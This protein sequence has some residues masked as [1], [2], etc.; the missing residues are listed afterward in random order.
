MNGLDLILKT[1][2]DEDH[3]NIVIFFDKF[4]SKK[5]KKKDFFLNTSKIQLTNTNFYYYNENKSSEPI[6]FYNNINGTI[7]DFKL[8]GS[9]IYASVSKTS[10]IDNYGIKVKELKTDFTYS[11]TKMLFDNTVLTTKNSEINTDMVFNYSREDLSDFNNKVEVIADIKKADIS[12]TDLYHFYNELGRTDK[13]HFTSQFKGTLNDF[14]L[15]NLKLKSD[16][17][18]II[19]GD[20]HFINAINREN[21]FVL[22]TNLTNLTSNYKQLKEL[23]PNILGKTLPSSF[24]MFGDF[25]LKGKSHITTK[26]IDAQLE[27]LSDL[28]K[29]ISDLKLTNINDIDNA[30]Y[31]GKIELIDFNLGRIINDSLVGQ[32]S[33]IADVDGKGFTKEMLNTSVI[34]HITKHQYKGYTYS[35][36]D[37]NGVFKNQHFDGKM[38]VND[39][40]IKLTFKGL[41]DLSSTVNSFKFKADVDYANFNKLNLFKRDEKSILKGKIDIDLKGNTIDNIV[42][43]IH[44][45]DA[46]YT[47]QNDHY[48]FTNF[49]V[50]SSFKDNVRTL[51]VNS[52]EI[53]NG[54][55]KGNFKFAELKKLTKNSLGSIYTHYRPEQVTPGQFLSFN[56]KIY[57]KIIGVFFP[58]ISLGKNTSIK[59][60]INADNEKFELTF[61]SPKVKIFDNLA[62]KIRLQIDNKNPLY[63]TLF[64]VDKFENKLYNASDI[65]LVNVTLND[66]L[67]LRTN[68]KGGFEKKENYNLSLY[69]TINSEN[70]SVIG[71]KKSDVDFKNQKWLIN[72][73]NNKENKVTFDANF[74]NFDFNKIKI[75]SGIQELS[76]N[77]IINDKSNKNLRFDFKDIN[78]EKI[79][80][81][82]DSISLK[83]LVN[84]TINYNQINGKV[85]PIIDLKINDLIVN[86]KQQGDLIVKA[87]GNGSIK[88]YNFSATLNHQK[89]KTFSANGV[90]DL[91]PKESTI[92]AV[93]NLSNLELN[94][95]SPLGGTSITKIRGK[96]S[97][98]TRLTGLL[99]NPDMNGELY[100][101]DA[102]LAFPYL[103]T[104]YELKAFKK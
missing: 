49:D 50:N 59:G 23:L 33:M 21:G 70:K 14:N 39:K 7:R 84:G 60:K 31:K 26:N 74:K 58:D 72:P 88:K 51:T 79:T 73:E 54:K 65:N 34:G 69:H 96:V 16:K 12:L 67:F 11:R 98:Q 43:K 48:K 41:A 91:T 52:K 64:S 24:E 46:S 44:F 77:G 25:T 28:G 9:K 71:F 20:L 45:T 56:F 38:E 40:N 42:G 97:G 89:N 104:E 13:I 17:K 86:R 81:R 85:S 53:I 61:K 75:F 100:V 102:G 8:E 36:I 101:A 80:P 94:A 15:T 68:F 5:K 19:N 27:I 29:S 1:Y 3:Q 95:L 22:N 76:V 37:V 10:F 57:D 62:E 35:N 92:D 82:I 103:N 66:T 47:N 87:Q 30:K 90:I 63:N 55:V 99:K 18:A 32:F 93:V 6:V 2:K 83:G 4:K 78:L